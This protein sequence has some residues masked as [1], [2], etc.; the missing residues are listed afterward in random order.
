[1]G[2]NSDY[3]TSARFQEYPYVVSAAFQMKLM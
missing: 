2:Y 3:L 1:M